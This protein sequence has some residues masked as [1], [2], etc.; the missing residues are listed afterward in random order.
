[1]GPIQQVTRALCLAACVALGGG[2]I[3]VHR[4]ADGN[5]MSI[6]MKLPDAVAQRGILRICNV[7]ELSGRAQ[8]EELP[9]FFLDGE[10]CQR[11]LRPALAFDSDVD[12]F[13]ALVVFFCK[14]MNAG[15]KDN[16][17]QE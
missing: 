2:C 13:G 15:K 9:D 16:Q 8:H 1:M 14:G 11:A 12:G 5:L 7:K 4:D 6:D 17:A 3:T 10:T